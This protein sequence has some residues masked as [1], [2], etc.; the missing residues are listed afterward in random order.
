MNKITSMSWLIILYFLSI[1][2]LQFSKTNQNIDSENSGVP[3]KVKN[4][5][6][7]P[8]KTGIINVRQ[9]GN[10][11]YLLSEIL[12]AALGFFYRFTKGNVIYAIY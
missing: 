5:A 2:S 11:C 3:S 9:R 6:V 7:E 1:N 8:A 10:L 4:M 12:K